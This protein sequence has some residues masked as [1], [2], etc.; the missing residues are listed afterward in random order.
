MWCQFI[1]ATGRP[2]EAAR[3]SRNHPD[4]ENLRGILPED[5]VFLAEGRAQS[6][7][8]VFLF[9]AHRAI[10]PDGPRLFGGDVGDLL[11][12]LDDPPNA[13]PVNHREDSRNACLD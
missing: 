4:Q 3:V 11:R 1:Q 13:N 12:P 2:P 6:G 7:D 8:H 10:L 9:G 5:P